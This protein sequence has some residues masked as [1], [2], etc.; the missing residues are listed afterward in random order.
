MGIS[1]DSELSP[2]YEEIGNGMEISWT[3][4]TTTTLRKL[5]QMV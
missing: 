3:E 2:I 1:W 4:Y 5:R